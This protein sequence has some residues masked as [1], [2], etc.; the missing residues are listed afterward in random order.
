MGECGRVRVYIEW[1]DV[2]NGCDCEGVD[3]CECGCISWERDGVDR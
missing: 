3:V 2:W 1:W